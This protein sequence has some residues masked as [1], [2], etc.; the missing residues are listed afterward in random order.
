MSARIIW[1]STVFILTLLL[2]YLAFP[3]LIV[4][5]SLPAIQ[6]AYPDSDVSIF[7]LEIE[8]IPTLK[9]RVNYLRHRHQQGM[10]L[11]FNFTR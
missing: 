6:Q 10:E 9:D 3:I 11:I 1:R 5:S 2:L 7:Q 4:P 8:R